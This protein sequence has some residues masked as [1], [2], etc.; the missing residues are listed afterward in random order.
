ME[1]SDATQRTHLLLGYD[2]ASGRHASLRSRSMAEKDYI[3]HR[4][5]EENR[6][7]YDVGSREGY[8]STL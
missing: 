7:A 6:L 3:H 4:H 1:E 5:A 2:H 8:C